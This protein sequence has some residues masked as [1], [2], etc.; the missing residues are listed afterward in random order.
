MPNLKAA[1]AMGI[2]TVVAIVSMQFVGVADHFRDPLWAIGTAV[3]LLLTLIVN[4]WIY[5]KVA[6][7]YGWKWIK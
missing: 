4:V 2:W 5:F 3:L 7:D 6:G 1:L